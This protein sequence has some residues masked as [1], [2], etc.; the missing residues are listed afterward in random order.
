[1]GLLLWMGRTVFWEVLLMGQNL[2]GV[3][4][5]AITWRSLIVL[6]R[7]VWSVEGKVGVPDFLVGL[8]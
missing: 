8:G 4:V 3:I 7:V 2:G 1:M 6:E 5:V